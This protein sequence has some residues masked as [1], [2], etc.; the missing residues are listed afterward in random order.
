MLIIILLL[1]F[2]LKK[3]FLPRSSPLEANLLAL[4][5]IF[6]MRFVEPFSIA[7]LSFSIWSGFFA[8]FIYGRL[9]E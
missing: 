1:F 2:E 4:G 3:L 7:Q 6:L 8:A 9:E 5:V